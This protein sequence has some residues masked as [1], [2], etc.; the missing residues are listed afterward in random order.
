MALSSNQY[1]LNGKEAKAN[2]VLKANCFKK[3]KNNS[4]R[5]KTNIKMHI[6]PGKGG[7]MAWPQKSKEKKYPQSMQWQQR[8]QQQ[9]T[10]LLT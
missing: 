9:K 6:L 10:N 5:K 8:Q 1:S 2:H 7:N 3:R 4:S